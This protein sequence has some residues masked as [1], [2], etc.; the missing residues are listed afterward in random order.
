[1][2]CATPLSYGRVSRRD[3]RQISPAPQQESRAAGTNK[4]MGFRQS[5]ASRDCRA[6]PTASPEKGQAGEDESAETVCFS[7]VSPRYF[8]VR[9]LQHWTLQG[10]EFCHTKPASWKIDF[11]CGPERNVRNRRACGFAPV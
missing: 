4:R 10:F 6:A 5:P 8:A 3:K 9:Q 1:M 7:C 11:A 2:P